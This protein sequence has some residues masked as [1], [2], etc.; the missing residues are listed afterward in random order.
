MVSGR[1]TRKA[2][3]TVRPP[4]MYRQPSTG[5]R[6]VQIATAG[7]AVPGLGSWP[8]TA[9]AAGRPLDEVTD[10]FAL[11]VYRPVQPEDPPSGAAGPHV[12]TSRQKSM[13]SLSMRP[14]PQVRASGT[15]ERQQRRA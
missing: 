6:T 13:K 12:G 10:P 5:A 11:E 14:F 15:T 3:S 2:A 1:R 8:T 4:G 7:Q 9:T